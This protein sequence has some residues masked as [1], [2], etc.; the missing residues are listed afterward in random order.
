MTRQIQANVEPWYTESIYKPVYEYSSSD[1][2][3]VVVNENGEIT[4][5]AKGYSYITISV[6]RKQLIVLAHNVAG[7]VE[8][9][10]GDRRIFGKSAQRFHKN[11]C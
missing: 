1:V 4:T 5:L 10:R 7:H 2:K 11:I 3:S 8:V 9:K 6:R